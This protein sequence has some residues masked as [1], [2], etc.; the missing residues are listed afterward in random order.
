M[1]HR[2]SPGFFFV[3]STADANK[4]CKLTSEISNIS[5][6]A[7]PLKEV[8]VGTK[9]LAQYKD[10]K[11]WYR[12]S[13]KKINKEEVTVGFIDYGNLEVGIQFVSNSLRVR[14]E[15]HT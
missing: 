9:C 3:Q 14:I 6:E 12:A 15:M 13:V 5:D 1:S 4:I 7:P 8:M 2:I 11:L 10:D